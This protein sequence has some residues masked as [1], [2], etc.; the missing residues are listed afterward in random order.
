VFVVVESCVVLN[1]MHAFGSQEQY[2]L[3]HP[4]AVCTLSNMYVLYQDVN[5]HAV[6]NTSSLF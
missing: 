5:Q 4:H 1:C 6:K 3:I 2:F